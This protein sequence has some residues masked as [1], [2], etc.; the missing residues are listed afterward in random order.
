MTRHQGAARPLTKP[1]AQRS[2]AAAAATATAP[3]TTPWARASATAAAATFPPPPS[4]PPAGEQP[5]EERAAVVA[6]AHGPLDGAGGALGALG[7]ALALGGG[8][9]AGGHGEVGREARKVERNKG[10]RVAGRV[11][12]KALR[13]QQGGG[14]RR[15]GVRGH[16]PNYCLLRVSQTEPGRK[17]ARVLAFASSSGYRTMLRYHDTC[18]CSSKYRVP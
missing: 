11:R 15:N 1:R 4:P 14:K 13:L 16:S 7:T 8:T 6:A 10:G 9:D 5:G 2:A 12:G 3:A 17:R 18:A